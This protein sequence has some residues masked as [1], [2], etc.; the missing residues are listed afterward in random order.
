M[1]LIATGALIAAGDQ[2][3]LVHDD[4]AG[5]AFDA[6][7]VREFV[8]MSDSAVEL[9]TPQNRWVIELNGDQEGTR[10]FLLPGATE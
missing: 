3:R 7:G 4:G 10:A 2:V 1:M 5:T 6:A 9:V 8:R